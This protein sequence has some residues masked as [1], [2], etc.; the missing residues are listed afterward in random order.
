[1][2]DGPMM[3]RMSTLSSVMGEPRPRIQDCTRN[4]KARKKIQAPRLIV[5]VAAAASSP[6]RLDLDPADNA[7]EMPAR[8]RNSGA[9][10]PATIIAHA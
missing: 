1:M 2:I 10:K 8:K 4:S 6:V 7:T 5:V 3:F 9:P